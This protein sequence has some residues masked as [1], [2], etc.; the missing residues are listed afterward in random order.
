[1]SDLTITVSGKTEPAGTTQD[2][3]WT[4]Q[5]SKL[6]YRQGVV[7]DALVVDRELTSTGFSG[8][9]GSGWERYIK[10]DKF[11]DVGGLRTSHFHPSSG[12][13]KIQAALDYANN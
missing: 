11:G 5:T 12:S 10:G 1:M 7:D 8:T 4:D 13:E 2:R 9:Q 3:Y 6:R